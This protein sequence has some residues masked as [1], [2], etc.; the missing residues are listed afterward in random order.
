MANSKFKILLCNY[1]EMGFAK[2]FVFYGSEGCKRAW[3][4][5]EMLFWGK[6]FIYK[7]PV[8]SMVAAVFNSPKI[9]LGKAE[10]PKSMIL[11]KLLSILG[12]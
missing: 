6:L 5:L 7:Y 12:E 11:G 4:Y 8:K 2:I 1:M 9:F 3:R 10:I